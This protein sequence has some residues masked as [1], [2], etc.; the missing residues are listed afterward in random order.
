MTNY[1]ITTM[2]FAPSIDPNSKKAA[3]DPS[4]LIREHERLGYPEAGGS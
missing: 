4:K 1:V 3:D 2:R